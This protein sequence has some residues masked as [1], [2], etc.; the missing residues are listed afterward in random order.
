MLT[1]FVGKHSRECTSSLKEVR[2][3]RQAEGAEPSFSSQLKRSGLVSTAHTQRQRPYM[4]L[5]TDEYL[6]SGKH[7]WRERESKKVK[8]DRNRPSGWYF[9][10]R[11]M[12]ASEF[13]YPQPISSLSSA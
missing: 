1:V 8:S 2:S 11:I 5:T 12:P 9:S 4:T 3:A 7:S 10:L 13:I 6:A